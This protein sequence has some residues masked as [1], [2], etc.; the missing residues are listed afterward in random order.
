ML[1][2]VSRK[3]SKNQRR[4]F[5]AD[6][7]ERSRNCLEFVRKVAAASVVKSDTAQIASDQPFK[8]VIRAAEKKGCDLILMASHGRRGLEGFL[9]GS[10]TQ[11][12]L[13]HSTVPVLVYR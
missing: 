9:P 10:E 12:V 1:S 8:E 7:D 11:K 13:T 2:P 6:T 5:E 4:E 3:R